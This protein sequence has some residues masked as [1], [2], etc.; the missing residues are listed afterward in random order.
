MSEVLQNVFK[1]RAKTEIKLNIFGIL[2]LI[3]VVNDPR[4]LESSDVG[5]AEQLTPS[6]SAGKSGSIWKNTS[7]GFYSTINSTE[8]L[9]GIFQDYLQR[10]PGGPG[11]VEM[12]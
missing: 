7:A 12:K 10:D 6:T 1:Q 5:E 2:I 8:V 3:C 9:T 4:G 11:R